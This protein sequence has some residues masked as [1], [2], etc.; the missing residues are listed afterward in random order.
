M[1]IKNEGVTVY[2]VKSKFDWIP[3]LREFF[4]FDFQAPSSLGINKQ[5]FLERLN[6][7]P[8]VCA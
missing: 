8:L 5:K 4:R 2:R 3:S 1:E 7:D 6:L